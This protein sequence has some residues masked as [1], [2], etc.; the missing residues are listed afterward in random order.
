MHNDFLVEL[1]TRL[2][3]FITQKERMDAADAFVAVVDEYAVSDDFEE[4]APSI[5]DKHLKAALISRYGCEDEDDDED[6]ND[7]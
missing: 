6:T 2:K 3:P 4:Q 5:S 7:W 1:W